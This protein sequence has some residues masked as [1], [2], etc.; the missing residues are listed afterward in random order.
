MTKREYLR[1]LGFEVGERGRFNE[2]MKKALEEYDGTFTEPN[3]NKTVKS[4]VWMPCSP[5][6]VRPSYAMVGWT[7][8]NSEVRFTGCQR[9]KSHMRFC[10]CPEGVQAPTIVVRSD[11]PNVVCKPDPQYV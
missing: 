4:D 1:S 9:C 6:P 7:K 3:S 11:D 5:T 2:A 8:W 10:I